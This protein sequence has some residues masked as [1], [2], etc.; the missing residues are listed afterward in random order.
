[1]NITN[2]T[3]KEKCDK[4]IAA[5]KMAL[6]DAQQV[7][8]YDGAKT[9]EAALSIM[10]GLADS[11]PVGEILHRMKYHAEDPSDDLDWELFPMDCTECETCIDVL[12]VRAS[13]QAAQTALESK[14]L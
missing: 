7:A 10:R 3:F 12:I 13:P 4:V 2:V 6:L 5:L 14:P 8:W 1:M 9:M 11:E